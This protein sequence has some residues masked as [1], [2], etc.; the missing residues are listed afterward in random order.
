MKISE[1]A[2]KLKAEGC[3]LCFH[4][5]NHDWWYSPKTDLRFQVPRHQSQEVKPKTLKSIQQVS[6]VYF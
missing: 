2:R 5:S 3:Y 4:G 6:G 1:L